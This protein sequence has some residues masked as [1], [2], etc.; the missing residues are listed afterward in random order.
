ME[1]RRSFVQLLGREHFSQMINIGDKL[2]VFFGAKFQ[3]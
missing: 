3:R 2:L 1:Q